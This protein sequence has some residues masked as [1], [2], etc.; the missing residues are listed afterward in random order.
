MMPVAAGLSCTELYKFARWFNETLGEPLL[1]DTP[2]MSQGC[3]SINMNALA[4]AS[5]G[6]DGVAYRTRLWRWLAGQVWAR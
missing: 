6:A 1:A 4:R 2:F 5:P 3:F